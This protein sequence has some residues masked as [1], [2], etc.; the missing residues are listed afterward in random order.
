MITFW[1]GV[2]YAFLMLPYLFT[3][4]TSDVKSIRIYT[5]ANRIDESMLHDFEK[6]TGIKV[7][8]NYY[9]SSEELITKLEMM[10]SMDCDVIMPSGFG[11]QSLIKSGLVKK[12][13]K[14]RCSYMEKIYPQFLNMYFDPHNEY[15]IPLYWDVFGLGYNKTMIGDRSISLDLLFDPNKIVRGQVC[16]SEDARETIFLAASY[17]GLSLDDVSHDDLRKIRY[18]LKDQKPWV[19]CYTD[20][21]QGYF[22]ASETFAVAAA[23]REIV[24]RKMLKYDFIGFAL[25]PTGSILR[26]DSVVMSANTKKD[27]LV[28]QF[29]DYLFSHDVLLKHCEQFCILPT[30]QEVFEDL[31]SKYIGVDDLYPGSST[32]NTLIVFHL[33]LTQKELNDFWI[34]VKAS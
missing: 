4:V 2:I 23:D 25:L 12:L 33:G 7:Y 21:Q 32:F 13:D 16:M 26:T 31:D 30:T 8:L 10:P 1:V 11:I 20:S 18:L 3:T 22:L 24:C 14:S 6:Q 28:Y 17:L 15:S 29:F 19:G 34:R 27:D 9:E 5:W